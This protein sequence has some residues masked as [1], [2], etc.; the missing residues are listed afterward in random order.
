MLVVVRVWRARRWRRKAKAELREIVREPEHAV[1]WPLLLAFAATLPERA[2]RSITLPPVAY[3]HPD[4]ISDADR[5]ALIGFLS[6]ELD[7]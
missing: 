5:A 1:Q 7:R 4:A 2:G 3:R 6:T